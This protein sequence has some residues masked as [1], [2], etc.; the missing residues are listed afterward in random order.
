L[1]PPHIPL[2]E[3]WATVEEGFGEGRVAAKLR[4]RVEEIE[5]RRQGR[6]SESSPVEIKGKEVVPAKETTDDK[7][8]QVISVARGEGNEVEQSPTMAEYMEN[9]GALKVGKVA[10]R[11]RTVDS[12]IKS[13]LGAI[14]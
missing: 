14:Q 1:E 4:A 2:L 7:F 13:L 12:L 10:E 11:T 8:G 3:A 5:A 9:R 6:G